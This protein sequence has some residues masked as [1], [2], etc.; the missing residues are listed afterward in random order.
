MCIETSYYLEHTLLPDPG[1]ALS[2]YAALPFPHKAKQ[3]GPTLPRGTLGARRARCNQAVGSARALVGD[4]TKVEAPGTSVQH[5]AAAPL[6]AVSRRC[7]KRYWRDS[8]C[9]PTLRLLTQ[10]WAAIPALS[11]KSMLWRP[12]ALGRFVACRPPG[13]KPAAAASTGRA[14]LW[15]GQWESEIRQ[16]KTVEGCDNYWI[17]PVWTRRVRDMDRR[18][19]DDAL[20]LVGI[21]PPREAKP[22]VRCGW[23]GS[24]P[25][26]KP[27]RR[28]ARKTG[29]QT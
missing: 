24:C 5:G 25:P 29:P 2:P 18:S 3:P 12:A 1:R 20:R 17:H 22:K 6:S 11:R 23:W 26:G 7:S 13:L 8:N 27:S 21:L 16:R 4:D 28:C 14:D 9:R 15:D 10:L 19:V